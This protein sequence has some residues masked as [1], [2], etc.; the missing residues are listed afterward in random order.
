MS[1][2][3]V[4]KEIYTK[5]SAVYSAYLIIEANPRVSRHHGRINAQR[6]IK[7]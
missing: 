4:D 7:E 3:G 1:T 6:K 2:L 5:Y